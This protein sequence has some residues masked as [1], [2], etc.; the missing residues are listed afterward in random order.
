M[1]QGDAVGY[2]A[3]YPERTS[4]LRGH[5]PFASLWH[6]TEPMEHLTTYTTSQIARFAGVHPNTIR[7]YERLGFITAPKRRPN[8]YRVFTELHVSQVRFVRAGRCSQSSTPWH[9]SP[10]ARRSN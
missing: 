10:T 7:L 4:I 1:L 3:R 8:G 2:A 5:A 6:Y 9:G